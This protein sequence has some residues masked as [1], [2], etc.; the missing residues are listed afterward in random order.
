MQE[1]SEG[2]S[3]AAR[4]CESYSHASEIRHARVVHACMYVVDRLHAAARS[5]TRMFI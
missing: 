5:E 2:L 3:H 4:F 1:R